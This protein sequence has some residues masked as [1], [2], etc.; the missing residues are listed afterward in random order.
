MKQL[1]F[2]DIAVASFSTAL[3][4]AA[5]ACGGGGSQGTGYGP[6]VDD[7]D[8]GSSTFVTA[9][10]DSGTGSFGGDG[11]TSDVHTAVAGD[12]CASSSAKTTLTKMPVDIIFVVDNSGSMSG[13]IVEVQNQIN[14]NFATIIGASGIDYRVIMIARH[15]AANSGQS[16]CVSAPLSGTT[17]SPI[18]TKPAET[19]RFFHYNEEVAS[20]DAWC[21]ILTTF[22]KADSTDGYT[23][24]AKGWEEALRANAFKTFIVVSDDRISCGVG[25]NNFND[26]NTIA[27]GKTTAAAFDTA[28]LALSPAQFGTAA[29]RN[30]VFH[31]INGVA[32][33]DATDLTKATPPAAPVTLS[34]CTPGA[35][36]SGT[37]HQSISAL[38]GGLRYP[39]CGLNYT[40]IFQAVAK[41]IVE[42]A[43][44][45]CD[46]PVPQ[47]PPGETL[48][49]AS[50]AVQYRP[51]GT[52]APDEFTE[53]A[54]EA[55]CAPGKFYVT[56]GATGTIHLCAA[57]CTTVQADPTAD[58]RV[59][60]GCARLGG[61]PK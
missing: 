6:G 8:G 48:D 2:R 57:T 59:V 21:K 58:I 4:G 13:E 53:V 10:D 19:A 11:S 46:F 36:N 27:A 49:L 32:P 56:G 5:F 25:I 28:L 41:G 23:L 52:G 45:A 12:A 37:G 15:G 1:P 14:T 31:S 17:C 55:A 35:V 30:Y 18:P 54:N 29:K 43:A 39:S 38:T 50:L 60:S 22:K 26:S 16:V 51:Q 20:T 7:V 40:T 34:M 44:I 47:P 24:H 61:G 9:D 33:F 42:G 3:F